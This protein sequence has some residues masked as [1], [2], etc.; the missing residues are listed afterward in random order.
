MTK[1][2]F[3]SECYIVLDRFVNNF[4]NNSM[5]DRDIC[6]YEFLKEIIVVEK[7]TISSEVLFNQLKENYFQ[8]D[9]ATSLF[10]I[11]LYTKKQDTIF[12]YFDIYLEQNVENSIDYEDMKKNKEKMRNFLI[13]K[14]PNLIDEFDYKAAKYNTEYKA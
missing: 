3:I 9:L 1:E 4:K 7:S 2:Q 12:E 11:K 8:T 10:I 5:D 13:N 6:L 14:F